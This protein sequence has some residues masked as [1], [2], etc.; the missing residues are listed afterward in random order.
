MPEHARALAE[1]VIA[2]YEELRGQVAG[3]MRL[4]QLEQNSNHIDPAH[5]TPLGN[6]HR[7]IEGLLAA[8]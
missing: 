5:F 6:L 8:S 4:V 7:R 1:E 2:A 3:G